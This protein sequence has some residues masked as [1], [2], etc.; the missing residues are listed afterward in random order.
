[1]L[2]GLFTRIWTFS[3]IN[4]YLGPYLHLNGRQHL[5]GCICHFFFSFSSFKKKQFL[6]AMSQ[7]NHSSFPPNTICICIWRT[8]QQSLKQENYWKS[9]KQVFA[10]HY[11]SKTHKQ[12]KVKTNLL[13]RG[14]NAGCNYH[15]ASKLFMT[16]WTDKRG[17]K[18]SEEINENQWCGKMN[19]ALS[20]QCDD[21]S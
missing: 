3:L 12:S 17:T 10:I 19:Y 9:L 4:L 5:T 16:Q 20:I 6:I 1:M 2:A 8:Q 15:G 11:N 14:Q 7:I 18:D 21:F 13:E